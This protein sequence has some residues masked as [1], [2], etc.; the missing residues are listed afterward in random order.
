M[1]ILV[2]TTRPKDFPGWTLV[3]WAGWT[4]S[5]GATIPADLA[6]HVDRTALEDDL[7]NR[8]GVLSY[9]ISPEPRRTRHDP[10]A[11]L[12]PPAPGRLP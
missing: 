2:T 12:P 8:D 5:M 3:N 9:V 10:P 6:A 7:A 4:A 1:R 11:E